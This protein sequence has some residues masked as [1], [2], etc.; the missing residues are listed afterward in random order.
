MKF[1]LCG[2]KYKLREKGDI[3]L[4]DVISTRSL[5]E[6]GASGDD[7]KASVTAPTEKASSLLRQ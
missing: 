1:G 2:V 7:N 3:T 4:R 5:R 6:R